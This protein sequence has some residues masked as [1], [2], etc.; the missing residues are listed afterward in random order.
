MTSEALKLQ[1]PFIHVSLYTF[2]P[3]I[4]THLFFIGCLKM[5]SNYGCLLL[6]FTIISVIKPLSRLSRVH[7]LVVP[8][9]STYQQSCSPLPP[10][11]IISYFGTL[12]MSLI[13][14][15]SHDT[16]CHCNS[17]TARQDF[18][19]LHVEKG[20]VLQ[21]LKRQLD[22]VIREKGKGSVEIT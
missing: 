21:L 18:G 12:D 8:S 7:F 17:L 3:T 5:M 2:H 1:S 9:H 6:Q 13:P 19:H 14:P 11:S 22:F 10:H 15:T 16:F 20:G 4:L